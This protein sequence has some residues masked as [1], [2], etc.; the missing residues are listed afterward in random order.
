MSPVSDTAHLIKIKQ[1]QNPQSSGWSTYEYLETL[2]PID[3]LSVT[4]YITFCKPSST[5][6]NLSVG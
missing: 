3:A 2:I 1:K 5:E 4:F 6:I